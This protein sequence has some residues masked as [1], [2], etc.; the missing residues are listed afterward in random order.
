MTTFPPPPGAPGHHQRADSAAK[1]LPPGEDFIGDDTQ[2]AGAQA[3][4]E[5]ADFTTFFRARYA[6]VARAAYL[7]VQDSDAAQDVAQEAFVRTFTHWRRIQHYDRPDLWVHRVAVRLAIAAAKQSR[8]R[9]RVPVE[10]DLVAVPPNP[11]FDLL[12]QVAKLPAAQRAAI[13]LFYYED[14]P[15]AEVADILQCS[16]ATAKV[17]LHRGRNRLGL[18][19]AAD[20]RSA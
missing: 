3:S 5:P 1:G 16:S 4:D 6:A 2:W 7:V 10:E 9:G 11:D 12:V 17:H 8:R 18:L 15:V 20:G 13:V 14:R 19:L